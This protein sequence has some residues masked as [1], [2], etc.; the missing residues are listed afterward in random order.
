MEFVTRKGPLLKPTATSLPS[1]CSSAKDIAWLLAW[2]A[3]YSSVTL[4]AAEP[5]ELSGFLPRPAALYLEISDPDQVWTGWPQS[6]LS[7]RAQAIG[8]LDLLERDTTLQRWRKTDAE[9]ATATKTRLFDHVRGLCAQGL[10]LAVF[11]PEQGEPQGLWLSRA[12]SADTIQMTLTAWDQVEPAQRIAKQTAA[13]QAYYVRT[14]RP[15]KS[16][17][18]LY[19]AVRDEYLALSDHEALVAECADRLATSAPTEKHTPAQIHAQVFPAEKSPPVWL[20][21]SPRAW[22]RLLMSEPARQPAE[23][24]LRDLW[25]SLDAIALSLDWTE[26]L[27]VTLAAT[28]DPA[29]VETSGWGAAVASRPVDAL[30]IWMTA[31]SASLF[32]VGGSFRP[33]WFLHQF[34]SLLNVKEQRDWDRGLVVLRGVLLNQSPEDDIAA[35]LFHD[36]GLWGA[37]RQPTKMPLQA[38]D[39]LLVAQ[40]QLADST[41]ASQST[42]AIDE[43]LTLALQ[44]LGIQANSTDPDHPVHVE[45]VEDAQ[46]R[47]RRLVG[48]SDRDLGYRLAGSRLTIGFPATTLTAT[49]MSTTTPRHHWLQAVHPRPLAFAWCDLV[50]VRHAFGLTSMD[51]AKLLDARDPRGWGRLFDQVAATFDGS[52]SRIELRLFGRID[53]SAPAINATSK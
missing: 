32:I 15:G 21:C 29:A 53:G 40:H 14:V 17:R 31:D 49:S 28:L 10:G 4:A 24:K 51:P 37:L 38:T 16:E 34:R 50:R 19:Y 33:A 11:V 20:T 45:R 1:R 48:R 7:R 41:S 47:T 6:L 42:Q 44:G 22:D 39:W 36:W 30:S 13:G 52:P 23:Q 25:K 43:A 8:V 9:V 26:G 35:A 27:S 46:S 12:R 18:R 3:V 5:R 2:Y